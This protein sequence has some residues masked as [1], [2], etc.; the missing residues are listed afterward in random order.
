MNPCTEELLSLVPLDSIGVYP[1]TRV[2]WIRD[3]PE[4][5]ERVVRIIH[6]HCGMGANLRK[7]EL[8]SKLNWHPNPPCPAQD[9]LYTIITNLNQLKA[10]Q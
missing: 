1:I 9:E 10:D 5:I 4:L 7:Y 2:V 3:D 6:R 8:G